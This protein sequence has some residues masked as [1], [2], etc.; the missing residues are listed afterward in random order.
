MAV[1][2]TEERYQ[3]PDAAELV[4]VDYAPLPVVMS[5]EESAAQDVLL[6]PD[7]GTNV[8]FELAFGRDE[9]LFD[10][11]EVVVRQ[12]MTNQRLA[13]VP[14]RRGMHPGNLHGSRNREHLTATR[15]RGIHEFVE[16]LVAQVPAHHDDVR[17]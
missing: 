8:A 12:R 1:V 3:G 16:L 5:A 13:A 10:G 7:V 4:F 14:D 17:A 9:S 15:Q 6:F 2:V 11:C